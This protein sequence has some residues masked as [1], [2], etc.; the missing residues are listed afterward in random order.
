MSGC[1]TPQEARDML[2]IGYTA[3]VVAAQKVTSSRK[4]VVLD[5]VND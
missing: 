4:N 3:P 2:N 5:Q 1:D